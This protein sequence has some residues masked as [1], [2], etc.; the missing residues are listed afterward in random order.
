MYGGSELV[1]VFRNIRKRM[2]IKQSQEKEEKEM[3]CAFASN[4]NCFLSFPSLHYFL[5]IQI[6]ILLRDSNSSTLLHKET[7]L[8]LLSLV[9]RYFSPF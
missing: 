3:Y 7:K 2:E 1:Q 6:L 4:L 9:S 8:S 5:S